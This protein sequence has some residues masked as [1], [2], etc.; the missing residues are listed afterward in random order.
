MIL[1]YK[2]CTVVGWRIR[3]SIRYEDVKNNLINYMLEEYDLKNISNVEKFNVSHID[4]EQKEIAIEWLKHGKII[5]YINL[6]IDVGIYLMKFKEEYYFI[7]QNFTCACVENLLDYEEFNVGMLLLTFDKKEYYLKLDKRYSSEELEEK[8]DIMS[9]ENY[10][11]HDFND[12]EKFFGEICAYKILEDCPFVFNNEEENNQSNKE[13]V[14]KNSIDRILALM[15]V[16]KLKVNNNS[17]F[18]IQTLEEY[19][20]LIWRDVEY[21]PYSNILWSLLHNKETNI[22]LELYRIV[23]K[24]YPYAYMYRLKDDLGKF[25]KGEGCLNI[26]LF[27]LKNKV[28]DINWKHKE[29]DAI[30]RI[31]EDLRIEPNEEIKQLIKESGKEGIKC[32]SWVYKIRNAI[33]H[34]SFTFAKSDRDL[35]SSTLPIIFEKDIIIHWI[36]PKLT[37]MY[38]YYFK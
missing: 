12:I 30:N 22:F 13:D 23:E 28:Q 20:R 10:E 16:E 34:L 6:T 11:S 18:S 9:Q 33:V 31:F 7:T 19:E 17:F 21:F 38:N 2:N 24:L 36:L 29:E 4:K 8:I 27:E 37:D 15:I 5:R 14:Q 25:I 35:D 3:M 1:N 32:A 26:D